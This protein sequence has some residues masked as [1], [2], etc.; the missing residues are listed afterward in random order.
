MIKRLSGLALAAVVLTSCG[1]DDQPAPA[2]DKEVPVI[3]LQT[4]TN[5]SIVYATTRIE[6]TAKDNDGIA[7]VKVFVDNETSPAKEFTTES[8][9]FDWNTRELTEG[10]HSIKIVAADAA[11]NT[12]ELQQTYTVKNTLLK[13]NVPAAY[14]TTGNAY[15][16]IVSDHT[17]KVWD[18]KELKNGETYTLQAPDG[19]TGQ[20]LTMTLLRAQESPI[21]TYCYFYTYPAIPFGEYAYIPVTTSSRPSIGESIVKIS[22]VTNTTAFRST[23]T[24]T[25]YTYT[26][27]GTPS[28]MAYRVA[29]LK[30]DAAVV[31]SEYRNGLFYYLLRTVE[32]NQTYSHSVSDFV[33][34]EVKPMSVPGDGSVLLSVSGKSVAY[35]NIPY[36]SSQTVNRTSSGAIEVP[37]LPL[38]MSQYSV[39]MSTTVA[40]DATYRYFVTSTSLPESMKTLTN[41]VDCIRKDNTLTI[42][43]SVD[44]DLLA[45]ST[46]TP[47]VG[48]GST[49]VSW[50]VNSAAS[51]ASYTLPQIPQAFVDKYNIPMAAYGDYATK[52]GF[53]CGMSEYAQYNGFADY[54]DRQFNANSSIGSITE[55]KVKSVTIEKG[56]NGGRVATIDRNERP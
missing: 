1:D 14:I 18:T 54:L 35:G 51:A 38:E 32:P 12:A 31:F 8:I 36:I 25:A 10:Q 19:F 42:N 28:E 29:I 13:Y 47:F 7:S 11:G 37:V 39:T 17:G 45:F 49:T 27:S 34:S 6:A 44:V 3:T 9:V 50:F 40:N 15:H 48:D 4:P 20:N 52:Y 22:G 5:N 21:T 16:I 23:T 24:E 56:S 30:N 55:Y 46:G 26:W 33:Q 43:K 53:S 2:P 41:T